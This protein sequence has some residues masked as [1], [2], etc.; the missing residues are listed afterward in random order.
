ME[1]EP[2]ETSAGCV[3]MPEDGSTY[4]RYALLESADFSFL[5]EIVIKSNPAPPESAAQLPNA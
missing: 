1:C 5:D 2:V 3:V 4:T